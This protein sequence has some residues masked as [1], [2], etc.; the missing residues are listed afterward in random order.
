MP[1][2]LLFCIPHFDV[3][4]I[5]TAR[6]LVAAFTV[7]LRLPIHFYALPF[8]LFLHWAVVVVN[9]VRWLPFLRLPFVLPLTY[10]LPHYAHHCCISLHV[11]NSATTY[12]GSFTPHVLAILPVYV[13]HVF[14]VPFSRSTFGPH[15]FRTRYHTVVAGFTRSL[16]I[17]PGP[18][19]CS[20]L[21]LTCCLSHAHTRVLVPLHR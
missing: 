9:S 20:R 4:F 1:C 18:S 7:L 5:P 13:T 11:T 12:L 14:V 10:C 16:L 6:S 3:P 15:A 2:Y 8:Y 17:L 19:C 21:L